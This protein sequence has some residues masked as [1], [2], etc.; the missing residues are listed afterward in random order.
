MSH[1]DIFSR[2]ANIHRQLRDIQK[3]GHED[4]T[5]IVCNLIEAAYESK[6]EMDELQTQITNLAFQIGQRDEEIRSLKQK[7]GWSTAL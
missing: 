2:L 4:V 6:H 5:D 7:L 3:K 1:V